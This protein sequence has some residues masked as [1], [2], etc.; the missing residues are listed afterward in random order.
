MLVEIV[1]EFFAIGLLLLIFFTQV[2]IPWSRGL[3][4][5]PLLRKTRK[6]EQQLAEANESVDE[7]RTEEKI[8]R[9]QQTAEKLRRRRTP[10]QP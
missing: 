7:A 5:F 9:T 3:P 4:Y 8:E 2:F 1:L 6:L 10:S